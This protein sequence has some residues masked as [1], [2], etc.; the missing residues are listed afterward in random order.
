M[1]QHA[2]V[3][4]QVGIHDCYHPREGKAWMPTFVGMTGCCGMGGAQRHNATGGT[5]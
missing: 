2:V 3:P 5:Q 4:T 1:P